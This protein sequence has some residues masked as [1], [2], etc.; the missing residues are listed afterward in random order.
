MNIG[1]IIVT[2]RKSLG[3]TQ[4]ILADKLHVSFQAVSKWETG[5]AF[6]EI[7]LL[8]QIADVLGTSVDALVGY[9]RPRI[10]DYEEK[11]MADDFYWGIAPN[12][13][14]YEIMRHKP[15]TKPVKVLDIGCGEG[16]DAIFLARNGYL[17]S[18]FDAAESGL[19]K[20]RAL[21]EKLGVYVDFFKADIRDYRLSENYDV[22]FSSGVFHYLKQEMR[23]EFIDNMKEHTNTAGIHA[24]NVFVNKP[25][26]GLPPDLEENEK[27]DYGWK[28]GELYTYYSDWMMRKTDEIIFDCN[29]GGISHKHCMNIMIASHYSSLFLGGTGY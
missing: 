27:V 2:K 17:V 19:D 13:M 11:Y 20:G 18:A 3:M 14:C 9:Q 8:P 4:Q 24:I 10:T 7:E 23:K 16:K 5:A 25:F 1:S 26:I 15:P 28:S 22:V 12:S 29:S 21:A 6:P